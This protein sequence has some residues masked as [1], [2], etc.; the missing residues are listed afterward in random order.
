MWYS[1]ALSLHV[2]G[3]VAMFAAAGV[4]VTGTVLM[5]RAQTVEQ[6]RE[7][8][9][10]ASSVDRFFPFIVLFLMAPAIYMV[11]TRWGWTTAWVDTALIALLLMLPLGPAINRRRLVA[12]YRA[13]QAAPAGSLSPELQAQRDD[14]VLWASIWVFVGATS[15]ILALMTIK[16]DWPG[17]LGTMVVAVVLSLSIGAFARP[18]AV[19]PQPG[20]VTEQR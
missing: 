16:P 8:A 12:I 2:F 11:F 15:G 13:S 18:A 19:S 10:I 1:L 9:G 14:P 7:R 17:S 6:L 4:V 20:L 3:A 5:R